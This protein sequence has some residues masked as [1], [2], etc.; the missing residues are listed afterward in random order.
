DTR[1]GNDTLYGG[2]GDDILFGQ[3]G[4]DTL[5]GGQGSDILY[6]GEHA[7]IFK[8][9]TNDQ[10]TTGDPAIDKIMDFDSVE[11]DQI[12]IGGLLPLGL[13]NLTGH[14]IIQ[15]EGSNTVLYINTE[16]N[17]NTGN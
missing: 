5:I 6:G 8:W 16:G 13:S 14:L 9:L 3:G 2:A 1:G 7:D 11:G 12:D 10:G 4:K 15:N 17:V